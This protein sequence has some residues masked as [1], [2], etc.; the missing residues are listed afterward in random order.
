MVAGK[1]CCV[2]PAVTNCQLTIALSPF[3][4][5]LLGGATVVGW[6]NMLAEYTKAKPALKNSKPFPESDYSVTMTKLMQCTADDEQCYDFDVDLDKAQA[7]GDA[8]FDPADVVDN[9]DG[10]GT[11]MIDGVLTPVTIEKPP[12]CRDLQGPR[13]RYGYP[14]STAS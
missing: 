4:C 1:C 2:H 14:S 10:T 12:S 6:F 8:R 11:V 3:R 5:S 7:E 13:Q 9:G